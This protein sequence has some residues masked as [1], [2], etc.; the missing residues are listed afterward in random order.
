[1]TALDKGAK[2]SLKMRHF[3]Y[4]TQVD[5]DKRLKEAGINVA[6]STLYR[7]E[8]KGYFIARRSP[9]NWRVYSEVDVKTIIEIVKENYALLEGELNIASKFARSPDQTAVKLQNLSSEKPAVTAKD[10]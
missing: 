1:M 6:R 5:L 8:E 3:S 2:L 4:L 10:S 9:G 7:M